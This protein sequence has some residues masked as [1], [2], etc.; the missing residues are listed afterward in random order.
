MSES[1]SPAVLVPGTELFAILR[2]A[3]ERDPDAVVALT[4]SGTSMYPMLRDRKDVVYLKRLEGLPQK[5]DVVL[6]QRHSGSYA[7]HRVVDIEPGGVCV[8]CGDNQSVLER[9]E[10]SAQLIAVVRSFRRGRFNIDCRRSLLYLIYSRIWP[11]TRLCLNVAHYV[12]MK[13]KATLDK[14]RKKQRARNKK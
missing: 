13:L 3:F 8:F 11:Q 2:E 14:T 6:F 4:T 7:L 1:G 12:K 9:V 5:Y 10:S